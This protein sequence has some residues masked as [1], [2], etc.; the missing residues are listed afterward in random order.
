MRVSVKRKN[1]F[2]YAVEAVLE[3]KYLSI[4]LLFAEKSNYKG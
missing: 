4:G 3:Y 2:Y 1:R